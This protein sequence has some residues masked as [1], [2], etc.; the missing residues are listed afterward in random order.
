MS[1]ESRT[2][3][4]KQVRTAIE[5]LDLDRTRAMENGDV[6]RLEQIFAPEFTYIHRNGLSEGREPY[7]ERLRKREVS[8]GPTVREDVELRVYGGAAVMTGR[9]RMQIIFA[10]G[11]ESMSLDNRFL[12]TWVDFGD[13]WRLVA[14]SST[15][16]PA[17]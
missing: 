8:Y 3:R 12:A 5:A 1:A 17:L 15:G 9:F 13:A 4:E 2:D 11:R 6:A 14:W 7:L 16:I 10:D